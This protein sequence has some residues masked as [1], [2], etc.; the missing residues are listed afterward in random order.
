MGKMTTRSINKDIAKW[1]AEQRRKKIRI[2]YLYI[3]A[4]L[5]ILAAIFLSALSPPLFSLCLVPGLLLY[6]AF[7]LY[8][9][10]A[11]WRDKTG[12][13]LL[14]RLEGMKKALVEKRR[15]LEKASGGSS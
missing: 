11:F 9:Y 14:K 2:L 7:V 3:P 6:G 5:L 12:K 10:N 13:A 8:G 15:K 4:N 1:R